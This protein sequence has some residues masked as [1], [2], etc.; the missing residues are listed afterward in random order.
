[1]MKA[2]ERDPG[3]SLSQNAPQHKL[4]CVGCVKSGSLEEMFWQLETMETSVLIK[5]QSI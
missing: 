3:L 1:M 2:S 5:S 4:V